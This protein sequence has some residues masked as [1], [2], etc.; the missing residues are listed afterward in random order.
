MTALLQAWIR[1][2][3]RTLRPTTRHIVT[4]H[5][6][7]LAELLDAIPYPGT[8]LAGGQRCPNCDHLARNHSGGGCYHTTHGGDPTDDLVCPCPLEQIDNPLSGPYT[9]SDADDL[10]LIG[11]AI[12]YGHGGCDR[13]RAD[14][15][16]TAT[17]RGTDA[18]AG[19]PVPADDLA[20][21]GLV[22]VGL[23]SA[24]RLHVVPVLEHTA[25]GVDALRTVE[26]R[27]RTAATRLESRGRIHCGTA[28][29]LRLALLVI[30]ETADALITAAA[31]TGV[32]A[33]G[34]DANEPDPTVGAT[35]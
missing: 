6:P 9:A 26:R 18:H 22:R 20:A 19:E 25:A 23:V 15:P 21:A 8:W 30:T 5:A 27:C 17:T 3:W 34:D 4:H 31:A 29:G 11:W 13:C 35:P 28:A 12:H 2:H 32:A 7:R 1:D 10:V 14:T 24:G 33:A 16:D